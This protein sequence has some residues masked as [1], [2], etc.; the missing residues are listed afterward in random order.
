M[1]VHALAVSALLSS[2]FAAVQ[3][4][5]P[6]SPAQHPPSEMR[7][8]KPHDAPAALAQ[9]TAAVRAQIA[10]ASIL[11]IVPDEASYLVALAMWK[12]GDGGRV[13]FP[14]LIDDNTLP[15]Q[16]DIARFARGFKPTR[17]VRFAAKGDGLPASPLSLTTA[18]A[19][20]WGT[21]DEAGYHT[22]LRKRSPSG[23]LGVVVTDAAD[24]ARTGAL[25]L[26]SAYGQALVFAAPPAPANG[27]ATFAAA[28]TLSAAIT[29]RLTA[30]KLPF[31]TLGDQIDAVTLCL[32]TP[33]KI[34]AG[35]S[36]APRTPIAELNAKP[37]EALSLTDLIGRS[38]AGAR[39]ERWA[40]AAQL[41]GTAPQAAYRAMSAIFLQPT[42]AAAFNGHDGAGS[43]AGHSPAGALQPL[44]AAGLQTALLDKP[45]QGIDDWRTWTAGSFAHPSR[46][47]KAAGPQPAGGALS[48]DLFLINTSGNHDFFQL[49][50]GKGLAGDAPIL[51]TPAVAHVIHSW[52][53]T[54][55]PNPTT[56][57]GRWLDRGTFCYVGSVYEP[58]LPAFVPPALFAQRLTQGW[59]IAVA[60]RVLPSD[61]FNQPGAPAAHPF[62][63][64][65]RISVVGDALWTLGPALKRTESFP[66]LDGATDLNTEANDHV[67]AR[68]YA[69]AF[70]TLAMC[71]RDDFAARLA[72]AALNDEP[73]K[74]DIHGALRAVHIAYRAGDTDTLVKAAQRI[75][76]PNLYDLAVAD[77]IWHA[78]WPRLS[79]T[80]T[81][82]QALLL[83]KTVRP[84]SYAWDTVTAATALKRA[85]GHE[86]AKAFFEQQ[87]DKAPSDAVKKELDYS[88]AQFR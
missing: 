61:R 60:G 72:R 76:K 69:L 40:F 34:T 41:P 31:N 33:L 77:E 55:G 66:A 54:F 68:R 52:S 56:V 5:T 21:A 65:W 73:G 35:A 15:A 17:T 2:T 1:P 7:N 43:F 16:E 81:A 24:P 9:R 75:D 78:L 57:G 71:G 28:D 6:P 88:A 70:H 19:A 37:G 42:S 59:P 83:S 18:L 45:T 87:R 85:V 4:A 25:A 50:S 47:P 30:L 11:V 12:P 3:P 10:V 49:Q 63:I 51:S 27:T 14:I 22:A 67:K 26:A 84:Y 39:L 58:Y 20:S 13:L 38:T 46:W 23:P 62:S 44:K 74:I 53:L 8:V 32:N 80:V 29:S 36:D 82:D 48:N 79:D 86:A 64:P